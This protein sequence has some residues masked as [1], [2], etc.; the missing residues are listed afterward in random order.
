MLMKN[1]WRE[2]WPLCERGSRIEGFR[3]LAILRLGLSIVQVENGFFF[4][5][6]LPQSVA[7]NFGVLAEK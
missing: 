6:S 2:M 1:V 5:V 4:F 7:G 3:S